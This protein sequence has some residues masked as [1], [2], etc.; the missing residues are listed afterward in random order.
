MSR[1][2]GGT[3]GKICPRVPPPHTLKTAKYLV[4]LNL[5]AVGFQIFRV[6]TITDKF[7]IGIRH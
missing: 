7:Q 4:F 6:T 3:Q 5:V 1:Q 2:A